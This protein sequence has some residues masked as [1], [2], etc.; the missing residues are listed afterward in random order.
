MKKL[1]AAASILVLSSVS[2]LAADL[3]LKAPM[4]VPYAFT[5]TGCYVGVHAGGGT[6]SD[7]NTFDG[8]LFLGGIDGIGNGG[9]TGYGAIAGGQVGCNYQDGAFVYGIEGEAAWSGIRTNSGISDIL[10]SLDNLTE[11]TK[12]KS[13][14]SVAARV[15]YVI[16]QRTLIYGKAG[17]A[18]G[19]F[20]FNT[21]ENLGGPSFTFSQSGNLNGLLLG[22]GIE[23]AFTQNW[24]AKLEYN[25]LNYGSKSLAITECEGGTCLPVGSSSQH[26]S[27]QLFKVGVNYL[28]NVTPVVA[29]Y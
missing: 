28:F 9:G 2:A 29:R 24:T 7:S 18:F 19:Q 3:P 11:T 1:V 10:G 21:T 8:S 12:N 4:P 22:A 13:D 25:W 5:W 16:D 6:M 23:H 27:I 17:W 26:A 14:Y 20:S 15:G